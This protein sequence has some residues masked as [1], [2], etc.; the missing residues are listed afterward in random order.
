MDAPR[1]HY[2][3]WMAWMAQIE[4]K[5]RQDVAH[6]LR[7]YSGCSRRSMRL[8]NPPQVNCYSTW[9]SGSGFCGQEILVHIYVARY[10][11]LYG[12]DVTSVAAV[13]DGWLPFASGAPKANA[14]ISCVISYESST[15]IWHFTASSVEK[16]QR[17]RKGPVIGDWMLSTH[18]HLGHRERTHGVYLMFNRIID[19]LPKCV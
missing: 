15:H 1:L 2:M 14:F 16:G 5:L 10:A 8:I 19:I 9:S 7:M 13:A 18:N 6:S 4:S 11:G 17:D 12:R 3:P